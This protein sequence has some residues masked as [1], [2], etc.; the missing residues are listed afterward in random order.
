MN[1]TA[2]RVPRITGFPARI[3]GS[4]TMRSDGGITTVYR[5]PGRRGAA[6]VFRGGGQAGHGRVPNR[7]NET[8]AAQAVRPPARKPL[9][10]SAARTAADPDGRTAR[11]APAFIVID[12][13]ITRV[14]QSIRLGMDNPARAANLLDL[15]IN[16]AKLVPEM[17]ACAK[18]QG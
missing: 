13:W 7:A 14:S 4:T 18:T 12:S 2:R 15:C 5:V 10:G 8:S 3:S 17:D 11:L 1:S 16:N 9:G 6:A